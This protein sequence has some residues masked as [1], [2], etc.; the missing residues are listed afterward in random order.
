MSSPRSGPG[1][2]MAGYD[3]YWTFGDQ[4]HVSFT[5]GGPTALLPNGFSSKEGC[6]SVADASGNL[7][8]YTDG[9]K[10]YDQNHIALTAPPLGGDSSSCHSAIIVPPAGGGSDYHIFTVHSWDNNGQGP[11]HHC[12]IK[13]TGSGIA[14]GLPPTPLAF[15]PSRAAEKLAAIPQV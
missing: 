8:F 12:T 1:G 6:A 10:V 2:T 11:V 15:G 3:H 4:C 14:L 5:G 9:S 13:L 7:L